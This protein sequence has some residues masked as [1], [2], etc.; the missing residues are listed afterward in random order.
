MGMSSEKCSKVIFGVQ[1]NR[2]KLR[3]LTL[4]FGREQ[5]MKMKYTKYA[6]LHH[7]QIIQKPRNYKTCDSYGIDAS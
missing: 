2:E 1:S 7:T 6:C 4:N 3:V 5:K